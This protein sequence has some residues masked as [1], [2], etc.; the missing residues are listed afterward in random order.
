MALPKYHE[1]ATQL[2]VQMCRGILPNGQTCFATR[3]HERGFVEDG[4]VHWADRMTTREGVKRFLGLVVEETGQVGLTEAWQKLYHRVKMIW[5]WA[6]QIGVRIPR[7]A[8]EHER[9][10]LRAMLLKVP[11]DAPGRA[12][13]MQWASRR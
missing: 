12:E 13:A 11:T 8:F 4:L 5:L 2:G 6:D 10:Q 1:I 9:L 3:S 7:Q